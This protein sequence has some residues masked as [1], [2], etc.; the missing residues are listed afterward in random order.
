[1]SGRVAVRKDG[2]IGWLVLDHPERRNAISLTMWQAVPEAVKELSVDDEV[3]VV[4]MRGAG[5]VAFAAGADI[6]EFERNRLGDGVEVYDT[7]I[8]LALLALAGMDKPLLAMVH[9]FCIGGGL[10]LAL[11][12]DMRYASDDAGFAIPA[13]RLG[14]GYPME[15]VEELAR[16]V[17]VSNAKQVL[18]TAKT[19]SAA[20]AMRM[21]LVNQVF[22]RE[23]LE[24]KVRRI[25][26]RIAGNS[27]FSLKS[28]KLIA[29]E[30][31]KPVEKR[32][33][34]SIN[35]SIAACVQ[36][37]DYQEGIKAFLEKRDPIF[38]G[39]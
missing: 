16:A 36:S 11:T 5:E 31:D 32:D 27:P 9:G 30:L 29:R 37:E 12:A 13:A 28:A 26:R 2:A 6:S 8:A 19:Y 35:R 21:G 17:G 7:A 24:A 15:G 38:K 3:R 14:V 39:R 25:A 20:E 10:A 1:M 22:A 33:L 23:E 4:V 34:D 18:F